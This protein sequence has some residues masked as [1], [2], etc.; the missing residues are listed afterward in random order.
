MPAEGQGVHKCPGGLTGTRVEWGL[1][2]C[3]HD[4][5]PMELGGVDGATA[6]NSS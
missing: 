5:E 4:A 3:V 6:Q 1:G 2:S